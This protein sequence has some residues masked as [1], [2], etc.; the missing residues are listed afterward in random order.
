MSNQKLTR[1][2]QREAA[3]AK[4][5]AMREA[6]K[7]NEGR[8]KLLVI[9]GSVIAGL[10]VIAGGIFIAVSQPA[11]VQ[12]GENPSTAFTNGGFTITKDLTLA[13][14]AADIDKS[15]PTIII[16]EDLQ[17]PACKAFELPNMPQIKELVKA[18]KYNLELHPIGMLDGYSPNEYA[19]R[20]ASALVCVA[21][22]APQAFLDYNSAL[23]ANQPEENTVGP[24]NKALA[25][26]ASSVG[27]SD[28][29]TLD[30]INNANWATWTKNQVP[31]YKGT[32]PG[33]DIKFSGTP[34]VIVN[35]Q[36]YQGN[37]NNAA[38]FLQ[39]LQTV[40]PVSTN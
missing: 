31:E 14:S 4:A 40:A 7:K 21:E 24:D 18:G 16:Y 39:W 23:Y 33:T 34:T 15:V 32:V 10:G 27:V 35:G 28:A 3:R 6:Q 20:A 29:D 26:L 1:D 37:L 17:C 22:G 38:M 13:K 11:P 30:C 19:S 5:R 8:K 12:P 9:L 36:Q 25:S 2:Q